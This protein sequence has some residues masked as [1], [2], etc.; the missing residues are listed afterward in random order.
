MLEDSFT[1]PDAAP[2]DVPAVMKATTE[3]GRKEWT[4]IAILCNSV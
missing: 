4:G 3:K 2:A 1:V